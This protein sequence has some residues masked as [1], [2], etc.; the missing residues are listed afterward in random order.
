[1]FWN[2]RP[3]LWFFRKIIWDFCNGRNMPKREVQKLATLGISIISFWRTK[4]TKRLLAAIS[5]MFLDYFYIWG[6][7]FPHPVW[8]EAYFIKISLY[9]FLSKGIFDYYYHT[10]AP[11]RT[12]P[13]PTVRFSWK[14]VAK[15]PFD[16]TILLVI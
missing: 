3:I 12:A 8:G 6:G 4:S 11:Q 2:W 13:H 9:L 1:M 7:I 10:R 15:M 16:A 5:V 14:C